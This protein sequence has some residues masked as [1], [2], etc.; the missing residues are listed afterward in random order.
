MREHRPVSNGGDT[1]IIR[2]VPN[3]FGG[4]FVIFGMEFFSELCYYK[5]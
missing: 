4:V 5:G 1:S 2:P 3:A